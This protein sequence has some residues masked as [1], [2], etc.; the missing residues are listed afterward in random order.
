MTRLINKSNVYYRS[1]T[2][3]LE[4]EMTANLNMNPFTDLKAVFQDGYAFEYDFPYDKLQKVT[5]SVHTIG[6]LILTSGKIIARDPLKEPDPRYY[7]TQ[8]LKPG[9]Y[10]V[11]LSVANFQPRQETRIACAMLRISE[12]PTVRWEIAAVNEQHPQ[13]DKGETYGYGVDT[14]TGCFMDYDAEQALDELAS[15]DPAAYE[16]A[17]RISPSRAWKLCS[18]ALGQ[19]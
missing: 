3:K 9:N 5:I 15:P 16:A 18:T 10:P 2:A 7:F 13:Q 6:N 11:S 17:N 12:Q 8:T 4:A 14:G 1:S 19:I